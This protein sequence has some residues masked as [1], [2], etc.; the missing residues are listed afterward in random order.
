MVRK[1]WHGKEWKR[2]GNDPGQTNKA[3]EN[4]EKMETTISQNNNM[5]K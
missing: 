3:W 2:R 4:S 1:Q 5:K